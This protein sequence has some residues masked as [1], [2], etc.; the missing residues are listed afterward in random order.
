MSAEYPIG[1]P[2]KQ[3]VTR[4][5]DAADHLWLQGLLRYTRLAAF[6][7]STRVHRGTE[8]SQ[9]VA[10]MDQIPNIIWMTAGFTSHYKPGKLSVLFRSRP[11]TDHAQYIADAS[12]AARIRNA[13]DVGNI[14]ITLGNS[15][16]S[17]LALAIDGEASIP[18]VGSREAHLA[19]E[20][21]V[22]IHE[23]S[24]GTPITEDA[25][26]IMHVVRPLHLFTQGQRYSSQGVH[27]GEGHPRLQE[28]LL[29]GFEDLPPLLPNMRPPDNR[30][31]L[32]A[33]LQSQNYQHPALV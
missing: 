8:N 30:E 28:S 10:R 2:E 24:N 14:A 31:E 4:I 9:Q 6:A 26:R 29:V 23:R 25:E 1:Y 17:D 19:W 15:N 11:D 22:R 13:K 12:Q 16:S 32:F 20:G 3:G 5:A 7:T 21:L 18:P 27:N 33:F